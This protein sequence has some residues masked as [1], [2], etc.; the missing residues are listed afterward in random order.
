[1]E[2]FV[3]SCPFPAPSLQEGSLYSSLHGHCSLHFYWRAKL[4]QRNGFYSLLKGYS[5]K[6]TLV[7]IRERCSQ[8]FSQSGIVYFTCNLEPSALLKY[9]HKNV[10]TIAVLH[11]RQQLCGVRGA[12]GLWGA[13]HPLPA[14]KKGYVCMCV[15]VRV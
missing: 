12:A 6:G 3:F 14:G 10:L 15:C 9:W 13:I 1:M 11:W 4:G 7:N 5:N 8:E 2:G